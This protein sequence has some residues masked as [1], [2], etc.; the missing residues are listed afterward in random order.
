[1]CEIKMISN[2][3]PRKKSNLRSRIFGGGALS[4]MGGIS[5]IRRCRLLDQRDGRCI[6]QSVSDGNVRWNAENFV[7]EQ[8]AAENSCL[9]MSQPIFFNP[10]QEKRGR[11]GEQAATHMNGGRRHDPRHPEAI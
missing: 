6:A 1:M 4:A 7:G 10:F 9:P 11:C 8:A 2:A 3:A 5:E